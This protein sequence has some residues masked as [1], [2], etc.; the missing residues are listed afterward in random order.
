L[1]AELDVAS[2]KQGSFVHVTRKWTGFDGNNAYRDRMMTPGE[3]AYATGFEP[4]IGRIRDMAGTPLSDYYFADHLGTTRRTNGPSGGSS[5]NVFTAFGEPRSAT[6]DGGDNRYGYIGAHG[7]Q[8]HDEM[9]FLHVGHRYYD[10]STGRF[11]QRD[12]IGLAGGRNIYSYVRNLPVRLIDP[13][14]LTYGNCLTPEWACRPAPIPPALPAPPPPGQN[15]GLKKWKAIF[16][17]L[18]ASAGGTAAVHPDPRVK[19]A[20]GAA[21]ALCA[22]IVAVLEW[23]DD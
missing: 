7:Y 9:P 8:A 20:A 3:L 18:G 19:G 10:P 16:G 1:S 15:S 5:S 11:L 6:L 21:G 17:G 23:F 13:E 14:G 2:F 12:P 4:G 22:G